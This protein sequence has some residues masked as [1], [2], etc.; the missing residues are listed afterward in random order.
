MKKMKKL[1][2]MLLAVVMVLAMAAPSFAADIKIK[3]NASQSLAGKTFDVYQLFSATTVGTD[4]NDANFKIAYMVNPAF[5]SD[6]IRILN[7]DESGKT[8]E[9]VNLAIITEIEEMKPEEIRAFA[10]AVRNNLNDKQSK[11]VTVPTPENESIVTEYTIAELEAGYYIIVEQNAASGATS[12]CMLESAGA[13]KEITIKSDVPTIDKKIV[14]GEDRILG[15]S[16]N[17]GDT[18]P[19]ELTS[20]VPNMEGYTSYKY[21]I[22]DT[23]SKGLRYNLN[24]AKVLIDGTPADIT[25][26]NEVQLD[27]TEK[28]TITVNDFI[29]YKSNVNANIV[30]TYSATLTEDAI[31]RDNEENEVY[32]EYSSNPYDDNETNKTPE[33]K[34]YVYNFDIEIDKFV[35]DEQDTKLSD[36]KFVLYKEGE[37]NSK[38]YYFWN[39][40]TKKVEWVTITDEGL[41]EAIVNNTITEV[42]TDKNGAAH[43][44][45]LA[46][47]SYKLLETV[48]PNGYNKLETPVEITITTSYNDDGT[49]NGEEFT[50]TNINNENGI[51]VKHEIDERYSLVA[52]IA[53]NAG[54][55]LPSTGG[56]G[57][58]IFYAVG[59]IL[60]AGA[61]F[62][63][64]RKKRA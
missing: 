10:D 21:I 43:F 14:S 57:T 40:D 24:S 31:I 19:F 11:T 50:S 15:T 37:N 3:G 28:L 23:L 33:K 64:V 12:L 2:S 55:L 1:L 8:D 27:E 46:A 34:V 18:I 58:T 13:S 25:V 60:M 56:I 30:I 22:H 42:T 7:I 54:A 59:I 36:A 32:L 29:K 45:G 39:S 38:E 52:G 53:N 9:Q 49:L 5:K 26:K 20:K 16:V 41:D 44:E 62:F 48:A 63:I 51:T 47:G 4:G 6:L 35:E 17:V 61:V